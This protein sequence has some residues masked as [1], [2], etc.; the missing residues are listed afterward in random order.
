MK[1]EKW[2]W[3]AVQDRTAVSGSFD[4]CGTQAAGKTSL[5][6]HTAHSSEV[7]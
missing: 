1:N 5:T 4:V 2:Q 6:N 7:T 3:E